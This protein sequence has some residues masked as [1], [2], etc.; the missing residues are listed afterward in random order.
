MHL[1][2]H[3]PAIEASRKKLLEI[4][5]KS[6]GNVITFEKDASISEILENIQTVSMFEGERLAII[7]NV[8]EELIPKI[9][10]IN[11]NQLTIIFWFDKEIDPVK[12]GVDTKKFPNFQVF[13]FPE[14]KEVSIFPLLRLLGGRSNQAFLELNKLKDA[15][16]E[17]QY[18]IT[19][20]LYLL[21]NLVS[22]PKKAVDFVRQ[23]NE[24]MRK[25]FSRDELINLY[26]QILEIDFKIKKGLLE[27]DHAGYLLISR[28]FD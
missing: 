20:I 28:F 26:K 3:G 12:I 18:F 16:F 24:R 4:K 21:R 14:A 1:L 15:G 8:S 25:N 10:N 17:N 6:G 11:N 19:M 23:N 2:L 13:F 7:E 22:T 27:P 9:L 5:Q